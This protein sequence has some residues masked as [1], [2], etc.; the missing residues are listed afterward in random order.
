MLPLN[1]IA[2][3]LGVLL[4]PLNIHTQNTIKECGKIVPKTD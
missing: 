2:Q 4:A 3:I 1:K